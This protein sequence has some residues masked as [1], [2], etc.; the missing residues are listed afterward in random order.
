VN[1]S[2]S[3]EH[4]YQPTPRRRIL[5]ALGIVGATICVLL[6]V[7]L[8]A[9]H[10]PPARRFVAERVVAL[11]SRE[12]I[13]FST[14]QLGFNVLNASINLRN[15]RIRSTT[16]PDA[17]AFA[18]IGRARFNFNLF[19][20]LRGRYVLQTGTVDNIDIHYVVDEQGRNN[21][22]RPPRD[23]DAPQRRLDYLVSSLSIAEANVRYENRAQQ[24]DARLP[25]SSIEVSGND[26][27]NRHQIRFEG[28]GGDVRMQDR[29]ASIDRVAGQIDVG[30][31]D[32]TIEQLT[33]DAMGSRAEATGIVS[34][35]DAPLADLTVRSAVD[36]AR[37]A[38]LARIEGPISGTITI[39]ATAAGLLS[40][41]TV[42]ADVSGSTL[43]FRDLRD[44]QMDAS[45][46]YDG[47][48]RQARISS[49][50]MRAPWGDI[51]GQGT[52][53][54]AG[55]EP[56]HVQADVSRLHAE[57]V[58]RGLHLP[59]VAATE[60]DGRLQAQW[61]GA[62]YLKASGEA[63]ATL[64]PTSSEMSHS[65]MPLGG[66]IVAR[67]NGGRIDAQL[68]QVAV[69]GGEV[70][71]RVTVTSDR[72]LEGE[73]S[74]RSADVGQLISSIEAFTGRPKGSL[75]PTPVAGSAELD[76]TLAGTLDA[77]LAATTISAPALAA[78]TAEGIAVTAEASYSTQA[79][80][81]SRADLTWQQARARVDG[82]VGLG[83]DRPIDLKFSAEDLNVES[84]LQ[85]MNQPDVPVSGTFTAGGTVTGTTARPIATIAAQGA[86]LVAY[87]EPF[88]SLTADLRLDGRDLTVNKLVINKPQPEQIGQLALTGTYN[89]DARTYTFDLRSQGV[90][91]L[92]LRL[93]DGR[94][95]RG[96]VRQLA[97]RGAGSVDSPAGTA[98]VDVESLEL[99]N[100]ESSRPTQF[101]R[102]VVN[103]AAEQKTARIT[104]SAER[105]N[106][107]A[108]ALIALVQP[109]E[110]TLKLRA[111]NLDLSALPLAPARPE[112]MARLGG[113]LRATIDAS[114]TL[115]EPEKGRATMA[116]ES[117][118]GTW[119]GRPF[120]ARAASPLQYANERL[121]IDTLEVTGGDT[122]LT[123]SGELPL[124]EEAGTGEISIDLKGTLATMAQYA[125]PETGLAGDGAVALTGSLRGTLTRI[126][127]D[128]TLTVDDGLILSPL[129]EPGF[130]NIVLRGRIENGAADIEELTG[131]WGTADIQASGRIPLEVLPRLPV[132]IPRM[133]RPAML[134][135]SVT[136]LDPS[137]F[138][139]AP[140][141]LGG[142]IS[143]E[144]DLAAT[145]A[146]LGSL[147]G[148][149]T[150]Q[151]LDVAFSGL[152]LT[153]RQPSTITLA[154]GTAALE[155]VN[156]TGSAGTITA[157]GSIGLTGDRALDIDVDGTLNV[158]AISILT[159]EIRAEGD[160][161]M[162]LHAGGTVTAPSV[163]GTVDLMNASIV[164]NE[165]NVAA[166][167]LNAHLDVEG[168]RVVLTSL[169]ADVNGGTL[170]GSGSMTLDGSR[171]ENV[172][173][174]ITTEGFAYDAPLD[175]RSLSDSTLRVT[176]NG[177]DIIVSG[178]VTITEGGLT[179][180]INFD[181][182]LVAAMN[183][184]RSINLTEDR[185]D[186]LER[187]R[188]KIDVDTATPV[189]VDNNLARAEIEAD[190]QLV[191]TPYETGLLGKLTLLEGSVIRLNE[192]RYEAERGLITFAD[193]RR[194]VPTLD[195][196]LNT[197]ASN[198]DITIA[199]TGAP[200]ETETVLTSVPSL[201][202]PDIMAMLV[203]G[204][205]LDDMR[206]EEY[207]IAR[208]Q[209]LSQLAGRV[210]STLGRGL[211]Q[212]TGFSE[213]RIEPTLIANETDPTARLTVG[214]DITNNFRIVF[215]TN[216]A[217][218]NDQIWVAEYD[219]SRRFQTRG[220]RQEDDT[221]RFDFRHD[222]RFGGQPEPRRSERSRSTVAAVNVTFQD[223][224]DESAVR[225]AFGIEVGDTYDFFKI[226]DGIQR[227]E[228]SLIVQGY[229]QS[230]VRLERQIEGGNAHLTLRVTR[231]P[232][233]E[234]EFTGVTP[235]AS[236]QE[237]VRIQ[238]HRGVFD[239]QRG[240]DAADALRE[241]LM[242]DN[243]LQSKVDYQVEDQADGD[244]RVTFQIQPGARS[245]RVV[246]VFEGASAIHPDELNRVV[247]TQ[248]LERRLFTDP[249]VVTELLRLY[250]R[251][252]GFLVAE[253]EEPRVEFTG[254]VARVV[255]A[256][257]EGPKFT[258]GQITVA[259]NAVQT[260]DFLISQLPLVAGG[261]YLPA[262]A[263]NALNK[264]RDLYWTKGYNDMRPDYEL[265]VDGATG[266]VD[267]AFKIVEGPQSVIADITIAGNDRVSDR[268]VRRQIHLTPSEPLDLNALA[269]SRRS[270]YDTG[271]FSLVDIT[272]RELE[273]EAAVAL[274]RETNGGSS[275]AQDS[276]Q[277]PVEIGVQV[278]EVQPFQ[279]RYGAS[280]DTEG[281]IGGIFDITNR[282]SLG[283]ARELGIR[284][285]YDSQVHEA[286]IYINQPSLTYLPK[287]T[288]T[289]Y[290]REELN[291]PTELTDPFDTSRKG[292]SVQQERELRNAYVWTY[293][294]R[295]ER[296]H[297]LTPTPV[298]VVDEAVTVSPLTTTLTREKRDEVLDASMGSFLSQAFSF[299]PGWLGSDQPYIKWFGQ[300]SH[301]F[302][303][304][305]PKR[306][307]FTNQILR[308]RFVY[309]TGIRLGLS[310]GKGDNLVPRTERFF[311]GGSS[312]LRGFDQNTVGPISPDR[313]P[314][315][316]EAIL[317]L[318]NE[319]RVPLVSILDGVLF[320]DIGNVF[321][322]VRDFSLTDLRQS[323]GVGLRV[324][325]P[326]LLLRGDYGFVVDP[327]PGE[328]RSAFYFSIGQAF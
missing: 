255:L 319:L 225:K 22:P 41:P 140:A 271:A 305:A 2:D 321:L 266:E 110:T 262:A 9:I 243:Y 181:T 74:G 283:G 246:L 251:E 18:T 119:N 164:S 233:V 247:E 275:E 196:R 282:N 220:V 165:P 45:A 299:S 292:A 149:I 130:S 173:L 44:I 78:G 256:V 203:T 162:K 287:T 303:L 28:A 109:W 17:P 101:G 189:L 153:Q 77:P 281:G 115:A 302:P 176:R 313:F 57:T 194:I 258:V 6:I 193:E 137:S 142:R 208:E 21:L 156:L 269:R 236:V 316:G 103:V 174:E 90:R 253:I 150:F 59:Y 235:P 223:G 288:G 314:L 99:V 166:E 7:A 204:R 12:Q 56:S 112:N 244:R 327:R 213:V 239:K 8:I 326:W 62:D 75:L 311:A 328:P 86:D 184:R 272:S 88:G 37:V 58:M 175:L 214:Q 315:G 227:L 161:A 300:Y 100:A 284:S 267:V 138:P 260:T 113:Q 61:P 3:A 191:G 31:D 91:L 226:R 1:E 43:Q 217:G 259:G 122:S 131:K 120:T 177:N 228:R 54:L 42:N 304:Q 172:D 52:I 320:T 66:R 32:V 30:E 27:T 63:D 200:G 147:T 237:N 211:Q 250:Y 25:I 197:R 71:G 263:E 105:F 128:L 72:R 207:E 135:A 84:V 209:V 180:D 158:A 171:V 36:A 249:F 127:P 285:R 111:D 118:E 252:Q 297:T 4:S 124:T 23:P 50:R 157:G 108:N 20:L 293:G 240:D 192:R 10:T 92:G 273:G 306:Q 64:R 170:K 230:R 234:M 168:A 215:S 133:S 325:T 242:D 152:G 35:F 210:G 96:D 286:R 55:S 80:T 53:A 307:P 125:P 69:P 169:T 98:D 117:L 324:R 159:N 39:D 277:K 13:E 276:P 79:I 312:T 224:G 132:E 317:V 241:W 85:A 268:L 205:T 318:N 87:E 254:D 278:R 186:L 301:Y 40:A 221:L 144:A 5:R 202:E 136:G 34:R 102:L 126:E 65:A 49:V 82:R 145:S 94:Q 24:I 309:A 89:L 178:Q 265:V 188:F 182:G 245:A 106:L 46:Q 248:R 298:G 141:E 179:G 68:V 97:A 199:V 95:V 121:S 206:G 104:A 232:I 60:V 201:P 123:V 289:L 322:R 212:A 139:G 238:W 218:S 270:L 33:L 51:T 280:Y 222:L 47:A 216:L 146:D 116:L 48:T 129:L 183:T 187:V 151:E 291:P 160:T 198:Y 155:E 107:E 81:I 38:P 29:A 70:N 163:N 15:V 167:N 195:L 229:L 76:A 154:S 11:L 19:Q 257:S 83:R 148:H 93:P 26:L 261:P 294:Y 279:I 114:G 296:A 274:A 290:F 134:K 185:N 16:W 264:I 219:V 73:V 231:G 190:L 295:F 67:G 143:A 14:D 310:R 323:V 308:P